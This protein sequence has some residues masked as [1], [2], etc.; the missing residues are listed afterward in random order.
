[1]DNDQLHTLAT[2]MLISI[3]RK[4]LFAVGSILLTHGWLTQGQVDYFTTA[5]IIEYV[6]GIVLIGITL[7]WQYAKIK[8]NR[9]TQEVA[10]NAPADVPLQAVQ[11]QVLATSSTVTSL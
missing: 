10:S 6:A 1:M 7:F 5:N 2:E 8:F 3:V 11:K 4:I 9:T